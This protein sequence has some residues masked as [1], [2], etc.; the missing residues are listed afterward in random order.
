MW[1]LMLE[2]ECCYEAGMPR[3]C[4]RNI[5]FNVMSPNT[6]SVHSPLISSDYYKQL[7]SPMDSILSTEL[8][9]IFL[10]NLPTI[11][12]C[13]HTFGK[14]Q[15]TTSIYITFYYINVHFWTFTRIH[16]PILAEPL[17]VLYQTPENDVSITERGIMQTYFIKRRILTYPVTL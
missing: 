9:M 12:Y 3:Y 15:G 6:L 1:D 8:H 11:H 17:K 13:S 4:Q 7:Y 16:C 14:F 10:E 2:M 5:Q